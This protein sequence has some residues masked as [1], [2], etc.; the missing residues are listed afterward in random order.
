MLNVCTDRVRP[1]QKPK[2]TIRE[3]NVPAEDVIGVGVRMIQRK[4]PRWIEAGLGNVYAQMDAGEREIENRE[5]AK[6]RIPA[7]S[8]LPIDCAGVDRRNQSV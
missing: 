5:G 2:R 1:R 8:H 6:P 3:H 7:W 4:L